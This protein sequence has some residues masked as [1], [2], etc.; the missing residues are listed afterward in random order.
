MFKDVGKDNRLDAT[1]GWGQVF[2]RPKIEAT[3]A[4]AM[5]VG[6][7]RVVEVVVVVL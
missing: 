4:T 2:M 7:R 3:V 6:V 5:N 1:R